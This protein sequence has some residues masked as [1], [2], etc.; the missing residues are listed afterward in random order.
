MPGLEKRLARYPALQP[1]R[2]RASVPAAE[3]RRAAFRPRPPL[4]APRPQALARGLHR[5]RKPSPRSRAPPTATSASCTARSPRSGGSTTSRRSPP[6]SSTPLA[7]PSSSVSPDRH[8]ALTEPQHLSLNFT[9]L[10]RLRAASGPGPRVALPVR[11]SIP[12]SGC[13]KPPEQ[14]ALGD[15]TIGRSPR[16][17][18]PLGGEACGVPSTHSP[19]RRARL[20]LVMGDATV[21]HD[22]SAGAWIAPRL[23]GEVG[24]VT[25]QVPSAYRAYARSA[26]RRAIATVAQ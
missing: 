7:I 9:L 13:E 6:K 19:V 2:V 11:D 4:A 5:H 16:R 15:P 20:P 23:R 21:A 10:S 22:A 3:P 24:T 25:G 26:T 1:R 8:Q 17:A 14:R 12:L 18:C